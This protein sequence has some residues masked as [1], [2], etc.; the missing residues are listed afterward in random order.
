ME[1]GAA[2]QALG[3][4][5]AQVAAA[6]EAKAQVE[7]VR[8]EIGP[9]TEDL[10]DWTLLA[11]AFGITGIPTLRVNQ[12]LPEIGQ[13]EKKMAHIENSGLVLT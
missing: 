10:A 12:V 11:T 3:A 7:V 1:L 5:Q 6:R 2:Q 4:V 13:L 9:L 8:A